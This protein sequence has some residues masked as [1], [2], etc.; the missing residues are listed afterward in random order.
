M[1]LRDV[2]WAIGLTA[3]ALWPYLGLISD[4]TFLSYNGLILVPAISMTVPDRIWAKM[5][6]L[7]ILPLSLGTSCRLLKESCNLR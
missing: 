4:A 5:A 2:T 3:C 7:L 6:G 1:Q